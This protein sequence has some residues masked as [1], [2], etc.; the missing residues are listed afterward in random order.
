MAAG[1]IGGAI[2]AFRAVTT[3]KGEASERA[4]RFSNNWEMQLASEFPRL[5]TFGKGGCSRE[6]RNSPPVS[7]AAPRPHRV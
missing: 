3:R 6:V 1:N 5:R 4:E 7:V 2:S